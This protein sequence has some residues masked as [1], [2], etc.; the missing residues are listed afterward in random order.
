[1]ASD[2]CSPSTSSKNDNSIISITNTIDS[3]NSTSRTTINNGSSRLPLTI[4]PKHYDLSYH[5][6]NLEQHTFEGTVTITGTAL[7]NGPVTS[8]YVHVLEM[9]VIK[10][11][12]YDCVHFNDDDDGKDTLA[13]DNNKKIEAAEYQYHDWN[14]TC[15]ICFNSIPTSQQHASRKVDQ[16][17]FEWIKGT[18]NRLVIDFRGILNNQMRGLYRST[19][20][21]LDNTIHTMATTQFEP[22]DARRAFPCMDEPALKATFR[23]SVTVPAHLH[24]ISNTPMASSHTEATTTI[25]NTASSSSS[26]SIDAAEGVGCSEPSTTMMKKVTFQTTPKMS[27]YLVALIVGQF[28]GVSQTS[29]NIVTTVYTVPGKASGAMFCLDVATRCLDLYQDL[30]GIPYP[31]TKSDLIAIPDFAAGA[32][33]NWYVVEEIDK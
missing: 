33:E 17:S 6:I 32:M 18:D 14:E 20:M 27:T 11:T 29:R 2:L 5:Q 22:T 10:A 12:L 13:G 26:N 21:G 28:D 1:M 9:Q 30:Y 16:S 7:K 4:Q 3:N 31:L 25:T 19:Y 24:C 8:I 23:L 15:E